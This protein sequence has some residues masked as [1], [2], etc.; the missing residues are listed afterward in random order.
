MYLFTK[1]I[2]TLTDVELW[3][4]F[5]I[6]FLKEKHACAHFDLQEE[7]PN[8]TNR[9]S[10]PRNL[11]DTSKLESEFVEDEPTVSRVLTDQY[12]GNFIK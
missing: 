8:E 9:E 1:E 12:N 7:F 10:H 4:K 3:H 2:K 5:L 6:F 11:I